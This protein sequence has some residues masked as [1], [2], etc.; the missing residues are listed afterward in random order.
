MANKKYHQFTAAT[1]VGT[2]IVLFGDPATGELNKV[3][4]SG[5]LG[6]LVVSPD[7]LLRTKVTKTHADFTANATVET[8][9]LFT[10]PAGGVIHRV[11]VSVS[12][13]FAASGWPASTFGMAVG[14][15]GNP[16]KYGSIANANTISSALGGG[17]IESLASGTII[18]LTG[19]ST[20]TNLVNMNAGSITTWIYYSI[21][22]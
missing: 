2:D 6:V 21:L 19:T 22:D 10:L 1:P 14:V 5:M 11:V 8:E 13:A 9:D 20:A 4:V 18:Q 17:G 3:T 15:A 16:S 7:I 12:I